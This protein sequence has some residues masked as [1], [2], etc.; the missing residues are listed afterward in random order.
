[1]ILGFRLR[2]WASSLRVTLIRVTLIALPIHKNY[3]NCFSL[4][5]GNF[6][7]F[8]NFE[9]F[10][11]FSFSCLFFP[12]VKI[13]TILATFIS[14]NFHTIFI[15]Y[16]ILYR[17]WSFPFFCFFFFPCFF[18]SKKLSV[19]FMVKMEKCRREIW[20]FISWIWQLYLY[21][22][23]FYNSNVNIAVLNQLSI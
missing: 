2:T 23:F 18:S 9:S 7:S 10:G 22:Y 14:C 13:L 3:L 11:N 17:F 20:I 12:E 15:F 8:G 21:F 5:F 4:P 16:L 19:Y 1:M 6:D